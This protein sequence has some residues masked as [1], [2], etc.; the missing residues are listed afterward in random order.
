MTD[1]IGLCVKNA[2]AAG[3]F[4]LVYGADCTTLLGT[5]PALR[6]ENPVGLMFVDGHEDTMP[7]NV[8]EDGEAANT[9][10]GLLL[11]LTG[12][13]MRGRLAERLPALGRDDLAMLGQRDIQ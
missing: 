12:H 2:V 13:L 3:R 4:P 8:S 5:V 9:E 10:I 6:D 11:G 7:L 1:Q